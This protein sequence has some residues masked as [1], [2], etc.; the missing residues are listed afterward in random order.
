MSSDKKN[1]RTTLLL[2]AQ[3]WIGYIQ[4]IFSQT[5]SIAVLAAQL[6]L[7]CHGCQLT[8]QSHSSGRKQLPV[9]AAVRPF[10]RH[11]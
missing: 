9:T 6:Y 4:I 2:A 1:T 11:L 5:S 3:G 7:G 10:R 8:G